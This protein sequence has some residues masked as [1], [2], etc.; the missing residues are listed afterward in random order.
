MNTTA[1][2]YAT[3]RL[4]HAFKLADEIHTTAES[5]KPWS[6]KIVPRGQRDYPIDQTALFNGLEDMLLKTKDLLTTHRSFFIKGH[7]FADRGNGSELGYL[8]NI[9]NP[10]NLGRVFDALQI[11]PDSTGNE[12]QYLVTAFGVQV[13]QHI[14]SLIN[15][16]AHV[17]SDNKDHDP[18]L[19]TLDLNLEIVKTFMELIAKTLKRLFGYIERIGDVD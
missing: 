2:Q 4:A 12:L 8:S 17:D 9:E 3:E 6:V 14:Q 18:L 16:L 19:T 15:Q 5:L 10:R 13:E 11:N 7:P 1:Q